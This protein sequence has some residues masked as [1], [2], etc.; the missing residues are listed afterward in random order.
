MAMSIPSVQLTILKWELGE[1][2]SDLDLQG[3]GHNMAEIMNKKLNKWIRKHYQ[4]F[5]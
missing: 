5:K 3:G 4:V 1:L 2:L